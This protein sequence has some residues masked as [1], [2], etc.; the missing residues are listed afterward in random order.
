M[1]N[2][3]KT[4]DKSDV[5]IIGSIQKLNMLLKA[6]DHELWA[7]LVR[8]SVVEVCGNYLITHNHRKRRNSIPNFIVLGG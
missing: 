7:D 5:G 4:L 3:C 8:L 2:F 1:N 6:K